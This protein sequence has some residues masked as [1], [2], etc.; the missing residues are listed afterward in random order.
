MKRIA[1]SVFIFLTLCSI[2]NAETNIDELPGSEGYLRR[3]NISRSVTNSGLNTKVTQS[4]NN[5]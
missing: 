3:I 5:K 1:F 2:S 4:K